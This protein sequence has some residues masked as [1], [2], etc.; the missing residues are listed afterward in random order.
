[1]RFRKERDAAAE[2]VSRVALRQEGGVEDD[3]IK[4]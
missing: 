3:I 2:R 4:R 1:V